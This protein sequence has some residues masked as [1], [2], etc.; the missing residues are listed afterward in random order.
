M[1]QSSVHCPPSSALRPQSPEP[2]ASSVPGH[3]P[4]VLGP[5]SLVQQS[6]ALAPSSTASE[7]S[8]VPSPQSS[9]QQPSSNNPS[10]VLCPLSSALNSSIERFQRWLSRVGYASYDPYDI[11]GTPYALKARALYYRKNPFGLFAIA[12]ILAIDI[13]A[14]SLRSLFVRKDRFATADAQ[15]LLAFLNLHQVT[16][17]SD[18][19]TKA[20]SLAKDLLSY[21]IRGYSGHCWGYPFDWQNPR[22]LWRKNTPYITCTP[23]CFEAFLG[24][25][26]VT[27]EDQHLEVARSIARFVHQDLKEVPTS[28]DAAAGSYSPHDESQVVNAGA[29]RAM[30]LFEAA[31]RWS[32]SKYAE[33]AHRNLNY[34][35]QAQQEDG[36][37]LYATDGSGNFIDHFHTCFNLKNL[38]KLNRRLGDSS[39]CDSIQRGWHYYRSAL[40]SDDGLP[41]T[42]AK[43]PRTETVKLEMYNMAEAITLGALLGD[44]IPEALVMAEDL[45][46]RL[47]RDYQLPDG[48]FVTR[49]YRGGL[50]HTFPFIRWPQA[51]LFY[52]LTNLYGA[53]GER[54]RPRVSDLVPSPGS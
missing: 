3:Q 39:V 11:W 43:S 28:S 38:W 5:R 33:S 14:P 15:L 13:L 37:W 18:Y 52:A 1:K 7:Q 40:F 8:S 35:L 23:Y 2:R 9:V 29:Y 34:I 16:R 47:A 36:S 17:D 54:M 32:D 4:S 21:S 20:R 31:A 22:G 30:V 27:G 50:R 25:Y 45:A 12:P 10:S 53:L 24:L 48:H 49:V 44:D 6:S 46:L 51:Q 41:M 19:L 42:Y 26:E